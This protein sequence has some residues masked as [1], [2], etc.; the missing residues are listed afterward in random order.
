MLCREALAPGRDLWPPAGQAAPLHVPPA[1]ERPG[2]SA[3]S[4]QLSPPAG[5]SRWPFRQGP[6]GQLIRQEARGQEEPGGCPGAVAVPPCACG[7]GY[8][9]GASERGQCPPLSLAGAAPGTPAAPQRG[10]SQRRR[11]QRAAR[12]R[13][14]LPGSATAACFSRRAL[15]GPAQ[16][17][18]AP[19]RPGRLVR[20][21]PS[22][23]TAG[24]G[25]GAAQKPPARSPPGMETGR[26][27]GMRMGM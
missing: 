12:G 18:P 26:G 6:A 13:Q 21:M 10:E 25:G 22:Q 9:A 8:S 20:G 1:A 16:P 11:S 2:R 17:G 15:E 19:R 27:T 3:E 24:L 23:R 4:P 7:T 5:P 14:T